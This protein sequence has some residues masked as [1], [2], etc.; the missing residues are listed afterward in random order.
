MLRVIFLSSFLIPVA[1]IWFTPTAEAERRSCNAQASVIKSDIDN[2]T[3]YKMD[4]A[5][6]NVLDKAGK[7]I[8]V[9]FQY[10]AEAE[11]QVR[12]KCEYE[13]TGRVV[14]E[15]QISTGQNRTVN[16]PYEDVAGNKKTRPVQEPIIETKTVQRSWVSQNGNLDFLDSETKWSNCPSGG[17]CSL[18]S[19]D[20]AVTNCVEITP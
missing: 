17:N 20:A 16:E 6:N 11:V 19:A 5:G 8:P 10:R 12:P 7:F 2:K 4:A 18:H 3:S 14:V 15:F 13:C 1:N 9:S